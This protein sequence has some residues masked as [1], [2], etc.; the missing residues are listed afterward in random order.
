MPFKNFLSN[1]RETVDQYL[2]TTSIH[3]LLYLSECKQF[4]EK[5]IWLIVVAIGLFFAGDM[6]Y[7]SIDEGQR[8]P[9]L[10]TLETTSVKGKVCETYSFTGWGA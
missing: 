8:N 6:I 9:L 2:Q 1:S 7:T 3:G 4:G 10:T 5:L